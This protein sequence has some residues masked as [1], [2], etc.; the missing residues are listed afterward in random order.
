MLKPLLFLAVTAYLFFIN[1]VKASEAQATASS[2]TTFASVSVGGC[3]HEDHRIMKCKGPNEIFDECLPT[4]PPQRCDINIATI[5][6]PVPPQPGDPKCK[7]GCRCIDGHARNSSGICIPRD[8]CEPQC[9]ENE[10]FEN[11]PA[12]LC[13]PQKC[14]QLGYGINHTSIDQ[15]KPCPGKPGCVCKNGYLRND[16]GECID[17]KKCP[18]CRGDPNAIAGCGMYCNQRCSSIGKEPGPCILKCLLNACDCK[19]G[20]FYDDNTRECVLSKDCTT[21]CKKNETFSTC[22]NSGCDARN[23]SQLG[24]PVPC[25]EPKRCIKGCVCKSGFL[26]NSKGVCVSSLECPSC[27]GDENA[28]PGCGSRCRQ[29]SNY[30]KG[31]IACPLSCILN[32]CDCKKEYVYDANKGKCVLPKDCSPVCGANEVYKKCITKNCAEKNKCSALGFDI[33][34]EE[35]SKNCTEG[36]LCKDG[37]L[38]NDK[39]VCILKEKCPTCRGDPNAKPGCGVNCNKHCSDLFGYPRPCKRI[40]YPDGCDCKDGYYYDDNEKQCVPPKQCTPYCREDKHE[41][42]STCINGGCQAKNCSQLAKPIPCIKLRPESCIK[43]CICKKDFLRADNGSC[44]PKDQCRPCKRPN[45]YYDKCPSPCP[46]QTCESIGKFYP[47]PA[48][49]LN[50]SA[51]YCKPAC[52]CK[53]GFF[54]NKIG[55]CISKANCLKCTGDFEYYTC[56]GAC[57]NECDK[58]ETQDQDR[59]P[60]Q[61]IQCNKKCYCEKGYARAKNN[62]CIPIARCK[63]PQCGMNER[64][65]KCP[66]PSCRPENCTQLGFSIPCPRISAGSKCFGKP[67]CVCI[68]GFVR[69]DKGVCIP[70]NQCPS[71]RG[72][73]NA[74]PG[75]GFC[76]NSCSDKGKKNVACPDICEINGCQCKKG[77]LY[78]KARGKCVPPKD[79]TPECPR[80]EEYAK[81]PVGICRPLNCSQLG[82]PIK[83][84]ILSEDEKCPVKP[85]CICKKGYARNNKGICVRLTECPS[86]GSDSNATTGCGYCGHRCQD[87]GKENVA[88]PKIACILNGCQCKKGYYHDSIQKKCVLPDDCTPRCGKHE[89][90]SD[91]VNGGCDKRNCTQLGQPKICI[92][93]YKCKKGCV[94]KQGYL[95]NTKGVCVPIKECPSCGGDPNA[96]SGCGTNCNKRCSD[97]GTETKVCTLECKEDGCDCKPDYYL[98]DITKKC[99]KPENCSSPC[100]KN[101]ILHDCIEG[102]CDA[103]TCKDLGFPIAC[104]SVER[105]TKGCL[106]KPGYVRNDKGVCIS[107]LKCPSCGGDKNAQ[108]GCGVNCGT[109][110]RDIGKK[111]FKCLKIC[112]YNACDCKPGYY[113]DENTKKCVPRDKCTPQCPEKEIYNTCLEGYCKPKNCSQ[114]GFPISCPRIDPNFCTGGCLCIEGHVRAANGTCIEARQCPSCGGDRF[115]RAGCGVNCGKQCKYRGQEVACIAICYDNACDCLDEYYLNENTGKC[116]LPNQCP[117]RCPKD[118]VYNSCVEEYCKPKNC[119]EVYDTIVCPKVDK[120]RCTGGCLCKEGYVRANNGTCIRAKECPPPCRDDEYFSNCIQ[121]Q[122]LPQNCSQLGYSIPCP[123]IDFKYC[124]KGCLCKGDNVRAANGSCIPK[125]QCPSCGGDS[126]AVAGCGMNTNKLCSDVGKELK[127]CN[128]TCEPFINRCDCKDG[129]YLDPN[130]KKCVRPDKCTRECNLP[131]EEYN[132]CAPT[133]PPQQCSSL[134]KRIFCP[135]NPIPGDPKCKVACVCKKNYFRNLI[136]ECISRENCQKCPKPHEYF[137]SGPPCDNVCATLATKNKRNCLKSKKIIERCYCEDGYARDKY[138]N[139]IPIADCEPQDG[140]LTTT[141]TTPSANVEELLAKLRKANIALTGQFVYDMVTMTPGKSFV[142]SAIS[143]LIPLTQLLLYSVGVTREQL[144]RVTN[145]DSNEEVEKAIPAL[146]SSFQNQANVTFEVAIKFY[147]NINYPFSKRFKK[148]AIEMFDSE[149]ENLNFADNVKAAETINK[150]VEN[151]T[152]NEIKDLIPPSALSP[153]TR[154]VLLNAMYFFGNWKKAFNVN[155]TKNRDFY[156]T[157]N[158]TISIPMMYQENTFNYCEFSPIDATVIEMLYNNDKYSMVIWLPNKKDGL[159]DMVSKMRDPELVV[160]SLACLSPERVKV[161]VPKMDILTQLDL[162]KLLKKDNVTEMFNPNSYNFKDILANDEPIFVSDAIQKC[163][164]QSNEN[165]TLAAVATGIIV[166]TRSAVRP[167]PVIK[168]FDAD[169]PHAFTIFKER[170]PLFTGGFFG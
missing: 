134:G 156:V 33:V 53:K 161:F 64:Y 157:P 1:T 100:G 32:G 8:Q 87:I 61:N 52:R 109:R 117:P 41:V 164:L 135:R 24:F 51:E 74:K 137:S 60:I 159:R 59:C 152:H 27:G 126:N 104:P 55:E 15:N 153:D 66:V 142:L 121:A 118:E 155:N 84:S 110:C 140:N 160:Q 88:C 46:P 20:Y 81:C 94:C 149:G 116:V 169:H 108:H 5:L 154:L 139:C 97:I 99:V 80:N 127:P 162:S 36:C 58:I 107:K 165:G 38:R 68:D 21:P 167:Q 125:K 65:E 18:S 82:F 42:Y 62:T 50:S 102:F 124:I 170:N 163:K 4:C 72:D 47:C 6:C 7:P 31:P 3:N 123:R 25:V 2:A 79:C 71:C 114:L 150:W 57:D 16:K 67:K 96:Q 19:P 122:C 39:G 89:I 103:K 45:E 29:C 158:K 56:G 148:D 48:I 136:G 147:G 26:R 144:L 23:C 141:T 49:P 112:N 10:K 115:A 77:Y 106:C 133:C 132:L 151:K 76:G 14:S 17:R 101:E 83:C 131:N 95:R 75:C 90:P 146:L 145:L 13:E 143:V 130:S 119:S 69:N 37:Y 85:R 138:N 40:C 92:H 63:E 111:N 129:F 54:R 44:I 120:S 22:M 166:S 70:V 105:C 12:S 9:G 73:P 35:D 30:K 28:Q 11:C 91:C 34:C 78:D 168:I 98:D 86:C 43:G 93:P 113:L 128:D